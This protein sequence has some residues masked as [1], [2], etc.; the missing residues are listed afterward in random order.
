MSDVWHWLC[1]SLVLICITGHTGTADPQTQRHRP[2]LVQTYNDTPPHCRAYGSQCTYT[3]GCPAP[4][5]IIARVRR[6]LQDA[7]HPSQLWSISLP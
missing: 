3:I 2:C 5:Q 1:E 7:A 4:D 6:C